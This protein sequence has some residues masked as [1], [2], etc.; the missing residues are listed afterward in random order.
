MNKENKKMILRYATLIAKGDE[1]TEEENLELK[2][3]EDHLHLAKESIL[4]KATELGL[5]QL[6]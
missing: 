6:R 4:R 2:T 5:A 3:I 1:T